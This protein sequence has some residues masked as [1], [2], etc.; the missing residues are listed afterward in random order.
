[1]YVMGTWW[2]ECGRDQKTVTIP[3]KRQTGSVTELSAPVAHIHRQTAGLER[4]RRT[5]Y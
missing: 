1:M 4:D 2:V 3:R 5:S